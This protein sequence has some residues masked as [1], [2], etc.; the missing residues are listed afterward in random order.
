MRSRTKKLVVAAS[1]TALLFA[2]TTPGHAANAGELSTHQTPAAAT[3]ATFTGEDLFTGLLL[4]YGP[5]AD[6]HPDLT[7]AAITGT[8]PQHQAEFVTHVVEAINQLDPTFF[9]TFAADVTSGNP[10]HV[11]HAF[12]AGEEILHTALTDQL[13]ASIE[14]KIDD[15][16]GTCIWVVLIAAAVSHVTAAAVVNAAVSVNAVVNA[17]HFWNISS[18]PTESELAYEKWINQVAKTLV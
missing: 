18:A 15:Q 12:Q 11:D 10:V 7:A 17:T 13:G 4:G 1:A 16:S 3:Q 9:D 14:P 5:V 8:T 6:Q 2:G